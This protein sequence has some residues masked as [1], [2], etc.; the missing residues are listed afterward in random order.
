[1]NKIAV[2]GQAQERINKAFQ[3]WPN[4][5]VFRAILIAI[6]DASADL[7]RL[8]DRGEDELGDVC[9]ELEDRAFALFSGERDQR[10]AAEK[11][12]SDARTAMRVLTKL[13]GDL[14]E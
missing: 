1:M 7:A 14:E 12:L 4:D 10:L 11:A 5:G 6:G 9:I 3:D 2:Q 8:G 13:A